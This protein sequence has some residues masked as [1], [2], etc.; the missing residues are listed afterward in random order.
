MNPPHNSGVPS[1]GTILGARD[2]S[3]EREV[4][5]DI[6]V[7]KSRARH[8][9]W[10]T[11]LSLLI[12]IRRIHSDPFECEEARKYSPDR[13]EIVS[14]LLISISRTGGTCLSFERL[15]FNYNYSQSDAFPSLRG[16]AGDKPAFSYT[17]TVSMICDPVTE[18]IKL[19]MT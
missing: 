13:C 18:N 16:S 8:F 17:F 1:S 6:D 15:E 5:L 11:L 9:T 10:N 2:L 3:V 14:R 19:F 7:R 4:S 12:L